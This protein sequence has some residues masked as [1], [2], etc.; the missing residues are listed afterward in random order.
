[1][2]L[3]RLLAAA[4]YLNPTP[5]GLETKPVKAAREVARCRMHAARASDG[6]YNTRHTNRV[7]THNTTMD[8]VAALNIL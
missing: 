1:M 2:D 6:A 5:K 3:L 4:F 8:P 7:D